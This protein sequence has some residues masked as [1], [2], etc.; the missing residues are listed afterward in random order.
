MNSE[1]DRINKLFV[2]ILRALVLGFILTTVAVGFIVYGAVRELTASWTGVGLNPFSPLISTS[3]SSAAATSSVAT[4]TLPPPLSTPVPWDGK[5][6]VSIL[7]LGLDY[8]DWQQGSG[9]PRTDSMM[10]LSLDPISRKVSMLSIPRDLWV[11][12]PGFTHN[13]INT[14]Y[15]S[16][17]GNRLPGGGPGL[18]MKAVEKLIG[19]PIQYYA[20]VDFATFERLIDEIGGIDVLVMERIKISPIGR[21]SHWLDAKPYH[22]DGPDALAYA[23]IRKGGGGDF[24]RAERQQQVAMAILDRVVGFNVLPGLILKSPQLY[25]ELSSGVRTNMSLDQMIT[26]AWLGISIPKE[27]FQLAVIGPP[28]MVGFYT[29][30]DGAQVLRPIPSEIRILRDQLFVDSSGL[31]P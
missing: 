5:S 24:R 27:N 25:Q 4:G 23:R 6:R 11:E 10:L 7:L 18:A 26:L 14:A 12:I 20:V 13:R 3:D 30:P 2:W 8:R 15:S 22:L 9:A 17:E 21:L 29:R 31:F 19:V 16:G 1:N 28:K